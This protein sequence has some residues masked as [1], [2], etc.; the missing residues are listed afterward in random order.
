MLKS[1]FEK[2]LVTMALLIVIA[3]AV[4]HFERS[5]RSA[6]EQHPQHVPVG[7]ASSSAADFHPSYIPSVPRRAE[8]QQEETA[9]VGKLPR[10]K[11][12]AWLTKHH[13]NAMSL[14]TAFRAMDDTNYLNEAATNFPNDP[15]VEL[16]V[17]AHDEFPADRRKWLDLF[18][19][20]SPG[21]SLANYLSA[22]DYFKNG[23]S[24][25]AIQE[26]SVATQ[27]SEF[28]AYN[29]ENLID[30]EDLYSSS[31]ESPRFADPAAMSDM[32]EEDL[33]VLATYKRLA[34][35]IADLEQQFLDGGD[36]NSAANL[37]RMGMKFADQIGGGDSG[38]Y[39]INQLVGI[40]DKSIVLQKLDQNASY[41]FLE[42]KTPAQVTQELKQEKQ[43]TLPAFRDFQAIYPTLTD[44]EL[45]NYCRRVE[46][47]GETEAM[48]WLVQEHPP[49]NP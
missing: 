47:Y 5:K 44:D 37:A 12:E 19:E 34:Q 48:K 38:K 28:N 45:A 30:A 9:G 7:S 39:L 24:A 22:Q 41:D 16:A 15:Q 26:L 13:R 2:W 20:S 36:G 8:A 11:V 4:L 42:G 23:N 21:N 6:A 18:K 29:T 3:G 25:A 33:P 31:G 27:K 1:S 32:A 35:G 46:V 10:G 49:G 14:L 40:A 17:L 43:S